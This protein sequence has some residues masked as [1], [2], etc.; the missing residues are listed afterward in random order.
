MLEFLKAHKKNL[1]IAL[2]T[3]LVFG[4][5]YQLYNAIVPKPPVAKAIPL[6]RTITIGEAKLAN[7]SIYPGAVHGRYE[8][9][10]AFQVGG[11]INARLVN[12]GDKVQAGQVLMTIDP[13]DVRQSVEAAQAALAAAISNQK[14]AEENAKRYR[15]LYAQ[16]ATSK[17]ALDNYNTQLDA[18]N[19]TLRQAQAQ[20]NASENQLDY[21]QLKSDSDGI[22]AAITGEVGMV[23]A[24]GAVMATVVRDNEREIRISVPESALGK[25]KPNQEA[26]ITFWALGNVTAKG[27]VRDIGSMADALTKTYRVNVAVDNLPAEVKLGMTAKVSFADSNNANHIVVPASAIYNVN[28]KDQV[29]LVKDKHAVLTDI[30]VAKYQGNDVLVKTGLKTGDVV[31]TAG[32]SKLIANQEVRLLDEA[33]SAQG[34]EKK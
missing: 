25:L 28:N 26:T 4:T 30:T 9:N 6:V 33:N 34:G 2:G 18:A 13:K 32:L 3:F 31:I 10:L 23:T 19:A 7:N 14:L 8:S 5:G 12:L 11:K 17:L 27:H 15:Q 29:W 16:G 24:A 22:V 21:T 1:Y 20:A